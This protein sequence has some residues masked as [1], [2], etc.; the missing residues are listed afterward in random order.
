MEKTLTEIG[1]ASLGIVPT[2]DKGFDSKLSRGIDPALGRAGRDA[3]KRWGLSFGKVAVAG[4]AGVVGAGF[5]A[6]RLGKDALGEAREAQ[7]VGRTTAAILK[8]TG[9]AAKLSRKEFNALTGSLMRKTAVDDEVIAGAGN[10]LLTFK[11]VQDETDKTASVFDRATAAALDLSSLKGMGGIEGSAKMLGKALNDPAAGMGALSRA[12]VT[13]NDD[14][15]TTI[16]R[17]VETNR[18]LDAQKLIL[19]EVESQVGGTAAKQKTS[20]KQL[21][22]AWGNVKEEVGFALLPVMEDLADFMLDKGVPAAED[23]AGWLKDEGVPAMKDF[24]KKAR[25]LADEI[26]PAVGTA[27]GV[28]KDAL[29]VAAPLAKD[30]VGA[31]NDMPDWA[32]TAVVGGGA[33][34]L[35]LN[36]LKPDKGGLAGGVLSSLKPVPV[37]VTNMGPGLGG[38]KTPSALGPLKW[39]GPAAAFS[40]AYAADQ[41]FPE[42]MPFGEKGWLPGSGDKGWLDLFGGDD[43]K[44][45]PLV[46]GIVEDALRIGDLE[47]F[48]KVTPKGVSPAMKDFERLIGL[49]DN[50]NRKITPEVRVDT[51]EAK[52]ELRELQGSI[53][54]L[55]L[56]IAGLQGTGGVGGLFAGLFPQIT[57]PTY[58]GPVTYTDDEQGRRDAAT[59][60]RRRGAD[61]IRR[62]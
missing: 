26:L 46:P 57:G 9:G 13:F 38:G 5:A 54:Q 56:S 28:A 2:L 58:N 51:R 27:L 7:E 62:P 14:Q 8:A 37:F 60:R 16:E 30:F 3:G 20:A 61:G 21:E 45:P 10:I 53:D 19:R 33:G 59:R 4:A 47:K 25:P 39:L 44:T 42:L 24:A 18:T 55:V 23:F 48:F 11:N 22:T 50:L 40:A 15:K 31:F 1:W 35:A 32:K 12:G 52:R 17:M 6:F 34:L 36:K 41:K 29:E 49:R 43:K